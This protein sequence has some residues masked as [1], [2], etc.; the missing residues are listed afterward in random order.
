MV[1]S[2]RW[3][4]I[5]SETAN[6]TIQIFFNSIYLTQ[7]DLR[8]LFIYISS[9]SCL[10]LC[11]SLYI[12]DGTSH[13]CTSLF[14]IKYIGVGFFSPHH[15]L[16]NLYLYMCN[17]PWTVISTSVPRGENKH[18]NPCWWYFLE[19]NSNA[20]HTL[21]DAEKTR[22]WH[23]L[24]PKDRVIMLALYQTTFRRVA[25]IFGKTVLA[26]A[27]TKDNIRHFVRLSRREKYWPNDGDDTSML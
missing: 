26:Q 27:E 3:C 4:Y 15:V 14:S 20:N 7:S 19:W 18:K 8:Y 9:P 6:L 22:I 5:F 23:H 13:K 12:S 11:L 17:L 16:G 24:I 21:Q 2:R 25:M 10:L 1:K